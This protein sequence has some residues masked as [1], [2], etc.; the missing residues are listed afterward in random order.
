M[1]APYV[2]DK[3]NEFNTFKKGIEDGTTQLPGGKELYFDTYQNFPAIG[4]SGILYID[5]ASKK[6]YYFDADTTAYIALQSSSDD[7]VDPNQCI[8]DGDTIQC[9]L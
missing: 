6:V 7:V 8:L 2:I 5:T 1:S 4:E 3:L 9:I